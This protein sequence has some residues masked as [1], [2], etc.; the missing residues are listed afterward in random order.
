MRLIIPAIQG[1]TNKTRVIQ[2]LFQIQQIQ[3]EELFLYRKNNPKVITETK[4]VTRTTLTN[5]RQV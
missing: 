2:L 4:D 3:A 1:F 5:T